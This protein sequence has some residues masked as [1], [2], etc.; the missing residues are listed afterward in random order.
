MCIS[1]YFADQSLLR[2]L[3]DNFLELQKTL[4]RKNKETAAALNGEA[5]AARESDEDVPS[6]SEDDAESHDT[7][8][9]EGSSVQSEDESERA[10]VSLETRRKRKRKRYEWV[11]YYKPYILLLRQGHCKSDCFSDLFNNPSYH[12]GRFMQRQHF[13]EY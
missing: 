10:D 9:E 6:D 5:E 1:F 12:C 7:D 11:C 8:G 2:K 4:L 3:L 13:N